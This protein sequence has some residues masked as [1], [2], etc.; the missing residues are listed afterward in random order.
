MASVSDNLMSDNTSGNA[1]LQLRVAK[2]SCIL[3]TNTTKMNTR[4]KTQRVPSALIS[5]KYPLFYKL[6]RHPFGGR[7]SPYRE[8]AEAWL[9]SLTKGSEHYVG[10]SPL[11]FLPFLLNLFHRCGPG[12]RLF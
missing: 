2:P 12:I 3:S 6:Y 5:E 9:R 11:S 8:R 4:L 10:G 1:N 7:T